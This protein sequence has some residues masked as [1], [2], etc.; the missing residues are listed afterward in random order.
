MPDDDV[1]E[2]EEVAELLLEDELCLLDE[3]LLE[4]EEIVEEDEITEE[5]VGWIVEVEE[6][7]DDDD[8]GEQDAKSVATVASKITL[9]FSFYFLSLIFKQTVFSINIEQT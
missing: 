5:E 1:V 6:E 7:D 3:E 9:S 8:V 4:L 2:E